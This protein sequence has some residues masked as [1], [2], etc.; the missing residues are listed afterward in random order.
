[1]ELSE[2]I[3]RRFWSKVSK[4]D[5]CW[6]WIGTLKENGYGVLSIRRRNVYAHRLSFKIAGNALTDDA[7]LCHRCDNRRCVRPDHLFPGTTKDNSDD[8]V[9]KDRHFKPKGERNGQSIL[10]IAQVEQIRASTE[11]H[12]ALAERFGVSKS[13]ISM[14]KSG[15]R[16]ERVQD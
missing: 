2:G 3:L 12:K 5:G 1:M 14:I 7:V 16:W 13:L 11:F 8:K 4:S 9:S 10:T 6:I 15:R